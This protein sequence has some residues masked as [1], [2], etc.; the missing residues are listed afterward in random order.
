ML[1]NGAFNSSVAQYDIYHFVLVHI[2]PT[3][4]GV[5][6]TSSLLP[7]LH[8]LVLVM[9]CFRVKDA[10]APGEMRSECLPRKEQMVLLNGEIKSL[11]Q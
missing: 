11:P 4:L 2:C 5:E 1:D 9:L 8:I 3:T 10:K 7:T 6:E